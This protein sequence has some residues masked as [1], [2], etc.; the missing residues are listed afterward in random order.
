MLRVLLL[1][2]LVQLCEAWVT[3]YL[4]H[5][6]SARFLVDARP[7]LGCGFIKAGFVLLIRRDNQ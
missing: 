3:T 6:R 2:S 7:D 4:Y 1:E 5:H